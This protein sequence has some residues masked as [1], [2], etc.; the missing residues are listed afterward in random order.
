[1]YTFIT[2]PYIYIY[3]CLCKTNPCFFLADFFIMKIQALDVEHDIINVRRL[4]GGWSS[5]RFFFLRTVDFCVVLM[6]V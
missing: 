6:D 3:R 4:K 1:M 2:Y 5:A